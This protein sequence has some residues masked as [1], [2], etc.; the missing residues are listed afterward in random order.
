MMEVK[1]PM[2]FGLTIYAVR[3][4]MSVPR[5]RFHAMESHYSE[6]YAALGALGTLWPYMP[7]NFSSGCGLT[8]GPNRTHFTDVRTTLHIP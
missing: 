1:A 4:L 7:A 8:G 3:G 6:A 2:D 5:V